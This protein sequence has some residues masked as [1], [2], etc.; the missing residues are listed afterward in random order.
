M[1][2]NKDILNFTET[3]DQNACSYLATLTLNEFK[4]KFYTD[5]WNTEFGI[6]K[7]KMDVKCY[8]NQ[9]KGFCLKHIDNGIN[10]AHYK[11]AKGRDNGRIYTVDFG[12]QRLYKNLRNLLTPEGYNDYDIVNCHPVLLLNE[13][14]KLDI[15]CP[16]LQEYVSNR[17]T[18][19]SE[20]NLNKLQVLMYINTDR[21]KVSKKDFTPWIGSFIKELEEIKI[22]LFQLVGNL[23]QV[24]NYDNPISSAVNKHLCDL[25]NSILQR[26]IK[27]F[28]LKDRYLTPMFDGFLTDAHLNIEELNKFT[29]DDGVKWVKKDWVK[30]QPPGDFDPTK[31]H[32]YDNAKRQMEEHCFMVRN[33]IMFWGEGIFRTEADFKI[34]TATYKYIDPDGHE[35]AIYGRWVGDPSKRCYNEIVN[36]PY[37]PLQEDPAPEG[38]YNTAKP[39]AFSYLPESE[40]LDAIKD[41][42]HIIYH[43][44]QSEEELDYVVKYTAHILQKPL[45]NP[46]IILV[47]KGHMEGAGKDT[48]VKT[49]TKVLGKTYTYSTSEMNDVFG[50]YNSGMSN[51]LIVQFNEAQSSQGVKFNDKI[52]DFVTADTIEIKEKYMKN[53]IQQ[54]NVRAI[55]N[56][57]NPNPIVAGRRP[58]ICQTRTAEIITKE[59]WSDYYNNKMTNKDWVNSLGSQLL[60]I[61]LA[62]FKVGKIPITEVSQNKLNDKIMPIHDLLGDIANGYLLNKIKK[63]NDKTKYE[64]D[65]IDGLFEIKNSNELGIKTKWLLAEWKKYYEDEYHTPFIDIKKAKQGI[66]NWINEYSEAIKYC[67]NGKYKKEEIGGKKKQVKKIYV[68]NPETMLTCLK[69][70]G[71]YRER[72]DDS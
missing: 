40:R 57:N 60:D 7:K 2:E 72:D 46:Q 64:P 58:M 37:N 67:E 3:L 52:K 48:I 22:K 35:K 61:D 25:E 20:N 39:F 11:Y 44:T 26:T 65:K 53:V 5:D 17:D 23:Y 47:I 18:V 32:T 21:N 71:R 66:K 30:I 59:W 56:S 8:F 31:L 28:G 6:K 15:E 63:I 49:L 38:T 29:E 36:M 10:K 62:D 45:E 4:A 24:T 33:P 50:T 68:M 1:T 70:G 9:V 12:I 42:R 54:N 69:N 41:Y 55:V 34:L 13:C 27:R 16:F 19:L 43:L 51:K 14:K